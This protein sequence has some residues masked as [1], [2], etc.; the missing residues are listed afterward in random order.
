[1]LSRYHI[2]DKL[3]VIYMETLVSSNIVKIFEYFLMKI[4]VPFCYSKSMYFE[5]K[6]G[7]STKKYPQNE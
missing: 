6:A 7:K 2:W 5:Y 1:M 3:F 4:C